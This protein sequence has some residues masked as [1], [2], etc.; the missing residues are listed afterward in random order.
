M[1][2]G[3]FNPEA[4]GGSFSWQTLRTLLPYLL[5]YRLRIGLALA[6]LVAAKVASV[7]LPFILKHI[8]DAMDTGVNSSTGSK[9]L[10]LPLGLLLAYGAVRFANVLLGEVRDALF[11]RVTERAMRR[12]GLTVFRHLHRLELG[13]IWIAIPAAYHGM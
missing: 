6:C 7:G 1:R 2:R 11:G 13:F 5:E 9:L 12:I 8:V 4:E 3:S 10:V